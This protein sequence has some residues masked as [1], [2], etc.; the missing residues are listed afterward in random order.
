[1]ADLIRKSTIERGIDP[2]ECVVVAYGGAG[3]THAV[4]YAHETG[5]RAILV[6]HLS[7]VFSAAGLL[8]CDVTHAAEM[9]RRVVSPYSAPSLTGIAERFATLERRVLEQF[10]QEGSDPA[11]VRIERRLGLRFR[12]QVHMLEVP[13]GPGPL[14]PEAAEALVDRFIGDY[15]RVYG[16]GALLGSRDTEIE[17][18]RVV[19]T[20]ALAPA[21]LHAHALEG[22]D[23]A[24]AGRGERRAYFE[25]LGF[26]DAPVYDGDAL[27]AGNV[28]AGPALIQRM[29]DSVLVPPGWRAGVD[30][31]LTL[32]V[33]RSE[34]GPADRDG[35]RMQE[36]LA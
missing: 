3:P 33:E 15:A 10:E 19:G 5:S 6:P 21:Q 11:E 35:A 4:G 28:V 26:V 29:G 20:L 2:R 9:S 32:R 7:T 1:M 12:Q 25:S 30:T 17:L 16:H 22:A 8:S 34:P 36:S 31:H 23:P 13:V 18:H 14:T 27:R 24:H